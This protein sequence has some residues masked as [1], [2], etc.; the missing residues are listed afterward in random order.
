MQTIRHTIPHPLTTSKKVGTPSLYYIEALVYQT[1]IIHHLVLRE[2]L[3]LQVPQE[4]VLNLRSRARL[5]TMTSL[6]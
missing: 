3:P 4:A 1:K 5:V 6:S 2:V